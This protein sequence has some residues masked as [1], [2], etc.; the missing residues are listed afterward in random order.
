MQYNNVSSVDIKGVEGEL[1]YNWREHLQAIINCSYQDSRDKKELLANGKPSVT[2]GNKIP[3]KPWLYGNAELSGTLRNLL[4]RDSKL[5]LGYRYQYVHW[6]YLTWEGYGV[7]DGKSKI[8]T[9]NLHSMFLTYS[10]QRERYNLSLECNNLF[11]A[12][13]YDNYM[14]QKPGRAFFCK[15]RLFLQ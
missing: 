11:D 3:N 9:Q 15:F 5:Q 8:P 14:L 2:Y 7:L 4:H 6:F 13:V 1:R 10:W 12:R